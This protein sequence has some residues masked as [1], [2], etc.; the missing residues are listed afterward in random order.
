MLLMCDGRLQNNLAQRWLIQPMWNLTTQHTA[1]GI[2]HAHHVVRPPFSRDH[3]N[4]TLSLT[5][6]AEQKGLQ[7]RMRDINGHAM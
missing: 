1:T 2:G 4:Q 6:T 5:M 7:S 3:Q